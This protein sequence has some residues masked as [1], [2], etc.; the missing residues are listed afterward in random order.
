VTKLSF[1]GEHLVLDASGALY[2]PAERTLIVADMHFEKGSSFAARG[3]LLPPYDTVATLVRL[4]KAVAFFQPVKI[5]A[6]GDSFHDRLASARMDPSCLEKI[7]SLSQQC[8]I[9]WI[10]G[11]HDPD[12]PASLPGRS[13][14]TVKIGALLFRHEPSVQP[15]PGE[16]SGHL[17][18]VAKVV[19][20]RGSLRKK[21]FVSDGRRLIMPAFGAYTGGLNVLEQAISN[22]FEPK[23]MRVHV[24]G[25]TRVFTIG[26]SQL[27]P[28]QSARYG[29]VQK[30]R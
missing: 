14:E 7:H 15:P 11:N 6:L 25:E 20:A 10:A 13:C 12:L 8:E 1:L 19:N 26:L 3:Q 16:I 17:H 22:L 21:A 28:D 5:I 29:S 30:L 2:W 27:K 4:E 18:P 23:A 9:I 24:C